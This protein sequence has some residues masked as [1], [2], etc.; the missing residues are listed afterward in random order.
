MSVKIDL[1]S[2]N[3][4]SDLKRMPLSMCEELCAEI[5]RRLI[6]TVL[7]NGG[8]LSS[9]LGTVELTVALHRVFS[10]PSD[11]IIWDVGHQS[12]THK[13][14]T[15]RADRF[16]SLRKDGGLSGF[17]KPSESVH[18]AFISGHSSN[19]I[20]AALGLAE[21]MRLSGDFT[22]KAIAV[23]GDG[24]LTGG[25]AYEGLNNAGKSDGGIVIVLNHNEMSISKNVG[26]LA[27]HLTA[28]RGNPTYLD[29]KEK[30]KSFLEKTP[31][32]GESLERVIRSSKSALKQFLYQST[33][34]ENLGFVY[35]G[36]VNGHN[37]AE[38]EEALNIA[39]RINKPV[40]VHINTIKGKGFKPA[41][42]NPGA[43]HSIPGR[44]YD[45]SNP[46][47]LSSDGYSE[48]F[49]KTLAVLATAD[50][51]ICAV[52]AAMKHATGL[53]RFAAKFPNRFFDAGIAEQHAVTFSAA[54][55][56]HG[57]TPVFAVYSSFLQ[58]AYD[59]LIHDAATDNLHIVLGID[60]AGFVGG[61]GETHQGLFD[62][63]MLR[64]IPHSSVYSPSCMAELDLC[65]KS[66]LYSESGIACVRYP[67]G[68]ERKSDENKYVT[69]GY[70]LTFNGSSQ[71][72]IGFGRT[73]N[74]VYDAMVSSGNAFDV[75]KLV[76]LY[77]LPEELF[78]LF[79]KYKKIVV[80]EEG[81]KLG[82]IGEYICSEL[83]LRGFKGKT[84]IVA[85]EGFVPQS[86][87]KTALRKFGLDAESVKETMVPG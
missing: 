82:G 31:L 70:Y 8:H 12:Y 59:Q 6:K 26:A 1:N 41:E 53:A 77:P 86:T 40:F 60:R 4:P 57:L 28:I 36:P 74:N 3:L 23:I 25:L 63:A 72:A 71:L 24:A 37:L 18:D 16:D 69:D 5:R 56:K 14:L 58:R 84:K 64:T 65:L 20:S 61:D 13:L 79:K 47:N 55:A 42:K 32:I 11:K 34:F 38:T 17:S 39:K 83:S 48:R 76:K 67:K 9:N 22:H 66:A 87:E 30:V 80:F 50:E 7:R 21:S 43:F 81:C 33:M 54:L 15:G 29:A 27:K 62:I 35:I 49:G 75:L 73:V 44:G 52:T 2:S 46:L 51:N 10:S 68:E 78:K 19:S 85:V 45:K